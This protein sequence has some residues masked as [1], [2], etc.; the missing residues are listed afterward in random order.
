MSYPFEWKGRDS[1]DEGTD[2]EY[3]WPSAAFSWTAGEPVMQVTVARE[4]T[5]LEDSERQRLAADGP[6]QC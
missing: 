2:S 3:E 6:L 4:I 5:H 1:D